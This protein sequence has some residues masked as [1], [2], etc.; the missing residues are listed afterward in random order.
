MGH[1]FLLN[2]KMMH[3]NYNGNT[4]INPKINSWMCKKEKRKSGFAQQ[5]CDWIIGQT[6]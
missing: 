2:E 3:I 4:L 5:S 1:V 6:S